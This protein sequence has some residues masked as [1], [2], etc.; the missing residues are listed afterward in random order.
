MGEDGTANGEDEDDVVYR[1]GK[2]YNRVQIEGTADE[3]YLMDEQTGDI[4][5]MDFKYFT[6]MK[7]NIIV[8]DD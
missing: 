5:T 1:N 4:F 3:E 7:D 6:N 2:K 8:E